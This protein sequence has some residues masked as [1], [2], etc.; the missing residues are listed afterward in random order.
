MAP[1]RP[2]PNLSDNL[3]N[4][5]TQLDASSL[6]EVSMKRRKSCLRCAEKLSLCLWFRHPVRTRD[7]YQY[8][9][10][11]SLYYKCLGEMLIVLTM[12]VA[13]KNIERAEQKMD[14]VVQM[15]KTMNN[16]L[17]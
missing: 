5:V 2:I 17:N 11:R 12:Q 16:E 1:K 13:E 8:A 14:H 7:L 6:W 3:L 9:M 15:A 10:A 4:V